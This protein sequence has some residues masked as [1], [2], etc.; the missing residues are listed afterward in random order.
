VR[1]VAIGVDQVLDLAVEG[2]AVRNVRDLIR[3]SKRFP[4]L[5]HL[6]CCVV[7]GAGDP[8]RTKRAFRTES[9]GIGRE[10]VPGGGIHSDSGAF[11]AAAIVI[12]VLSEANYLM[13]RI[14]RDVINFAPVNVV[15]CLDASLDRK[16]GIPLSAWVL[17]F[18]FP[19][20]KLACL[21]ERWKIAGIES[22]SGRTKS[23]ATRSIRIG[24]DRAYDPAHIIVASY[25]GVIGRA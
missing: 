23:V 4:D 17:V 3:R 12:A 7:I 21:D 15:D 2:V 18:V 5:E 10:T 22:Y 20:R 6:T 1:T 24:G 19:S 8:I 25:I 9:A 14:A 16:V 11:E 13:D